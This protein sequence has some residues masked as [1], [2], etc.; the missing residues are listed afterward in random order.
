[1]APQPQHQ[2][3]PPIMNLAIRTNNSDDIDA[4][5]ETIA[6]QVRNAAT[7]VAGL[8]AEN[9]HAYLYVLSS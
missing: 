6:E 5:L 7:L 1:M 2:A 8:A 4:E 3:A 9:S